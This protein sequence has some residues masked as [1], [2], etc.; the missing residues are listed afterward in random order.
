MLRE[1]RVRRGGGDGRRF[2]QPVMADLLGY[3][4]RQYQ[5]LE[6]PGHPSLPP[7]RKLELIARRLG[8]DTSRLFDR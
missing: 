1:E 6:D 8:L 4:L 2:P 7:R 5:R 3:S